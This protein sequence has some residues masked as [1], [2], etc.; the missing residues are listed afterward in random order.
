M[1]DCS[2]DLLKGLS[3]ADLIVKSRIDEDCWVHSEEAFNRS[4]YHYALNPSDSFNKDTTEIINRD[5]RTIHIDDLKLIQDL[6]DS[7]GHL[8]D[9]IVIDFLEIDLIKGKKFIRSLNEAKCSAFITKLGLINCRSNVLDAFNTNFLFPK[10]TYLRFSS[11]PMHNFKIRSDLKIENIFIS[12][13]ALKVG[14]T[15]T[16]DWSFFNGNIPGLIHFAVKLP[17]SLA[18]S[19]IDESLIIQFLQENPQIFR[20]QLDYCN[21]NF[22]HEM[23]EAIPNLQDLMLNYLSDDYLNYDYTV[24]FQNVKYL[25]IKTIDNKIP[26]QLMFDH[27]R[28]FDLV[29]SPKFTDKWVK[30][31]AEH[32]NKD[33]DE[34]RLNTG[35][36]DRE[37]FG[38]ISKNG[39]RF[40]IAQIYC[41]S[42]ILADDI[43]SFIENSVLLKGLQVI[44][45]MEKAEMNRF[46]ENFPANWQIEKLSET[47]AKMTLIRM[48]K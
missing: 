21:L 5:T 35:L 34:F 43:F 26:E 8:I 1:L 39:L 13:V 28:R 11:S 30:F 33:F 41:L 48:T 36:M 45:R 38:H 23:S 20:I 31:M 22:L 42:P 3:I 24:H 14:N 4:F 19:Q 9:F 2:P 16:S 27:L 6:I 12:G 7:F 37:Q 25:Y 47:V 44:C 15:K 40:R 29:I 32:I 17:K 46:K 18:E 10:L